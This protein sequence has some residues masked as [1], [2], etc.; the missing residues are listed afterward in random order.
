MPIE[1]EVSNG[2]GDGAS[3]FH[4]HVNQTFAGLDVIGI[5]RNR[6]IQQDDDQPTS[7]ETQHHL[8][9]A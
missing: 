1:R 5:T 8:D 2:F 4:I 3:D 7:N 9:A 6:P